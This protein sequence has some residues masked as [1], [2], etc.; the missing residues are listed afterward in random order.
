MRVYRLIRFLLVRGAR[1][2]SLTI[3]TKVVANAIANSTKI[4]YVGTYYER[5]VIDARPHNI[6]QVHLR[7]P[8]L[9]TN[10]KGSVLTILF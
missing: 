10:G 2:Q 9:K 7:K 5:L 4:K 3:N 1:R 8:I 6:D